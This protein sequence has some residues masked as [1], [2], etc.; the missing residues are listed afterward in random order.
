MLFVF[1]YRANKIRSKKISVLLHKSDD[2]PNISSCSVHV[3][4]QKIIDT[5]VRFFTLSSMHLMLPLITSFLFR[6]RVASLTSRSLKG[7]ASS[8]LARLS[9]TTAHTI[10]STPTKPATKK[11]PIFCDRVALTLTITASSSCKS[12]LKH[13]ILYTLSVRVH[14]V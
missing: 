1:G 4:F 7:R 9:A 14:H 13:A 12:V 6:F 3:H 11:S 8:F 2:F 10:V 5:G